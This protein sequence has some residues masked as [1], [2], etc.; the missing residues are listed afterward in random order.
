MD[1]VRSGKE[2]IG[3]CVG[4]CRGK[5]ERSVNYTDHVQDGPKDS[6]GLYWVT[7]Q[8]IAKHAKTIEKRRLWEHLATIDGG[9][10]LLRKDPDYHAFVAEMISIGRL[11]PEDDQPRIPPM[12]RHEWEDLNEQIAKLRIRRSTRL[13]DHFDSSTLSA[14]SPEKSNSK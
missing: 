12:R 1:H 7:T 9:E 11:I 3:F 5:A 14:R 13:R 4:R 2:A 6:E 10:G 8:L